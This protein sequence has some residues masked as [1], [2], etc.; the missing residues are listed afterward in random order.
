LSA[1]AYLFGNFDFN[2]T[3]LAPPGTKNT[4]HSKPEQ[5]V[6]WDPN[7]KVGWYIGPSTNHYR[8]MKCFLPLT[9][10][11]GDTDTFMLIPH[12]IPILAVKI[13]GFYTRWRQIS[14]PY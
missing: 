2:K 3:P 11:E 6:I 7:G 8:C 14:L 10:T 12:N 13:D 1:Y 5:Q 4:I 9:Q